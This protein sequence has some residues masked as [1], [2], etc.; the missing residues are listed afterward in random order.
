MEKVEEA[1]STLTNAVN[2]GFRQTNENLDKLNGTVKDEGRKTRGLVGWNLFFTLLVLGLIAYC[3]FFNT[4]C[5]TT[6][7]EPCDTFT[8]VAPVNLHFVLAASIV[9]KKS[10]KVFRLNNG[11]MSTDTSTVAIAA[12]A[13]GTTLWENINTMFEHEDKMVEIITSDKPD[14]CGNI[15]VKS[16]REYLAKKEVATPPSAEPAPNPKQKSKAKM[17]EG[18]DPAPS[19]QK[20]SNASGSG[21]VE[22]DRSI[23]GTKEAFATM[24][25]P[26]VIKKTITLVDGTNKVLW[27]N[28]AN[29]VAVNP[30]I[31]SGDHVGV[32]VMN[33]LDSLFQKTRE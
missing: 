5:N 17:Q 19:E 4:T 12:D 14:S 20:Q 31:K 25:N 30:E 15:Y 33:K 26:S 32:L 13:A 23:A 16:F 27:E 24:R 8:K 9:D 18:S 21:V 11:E 3:C 7:E 10:V 28:T 1:L 6:K 22:Y 2:N 29:I